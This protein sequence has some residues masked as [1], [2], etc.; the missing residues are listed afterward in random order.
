MHD[1]LYTLD[2][3]LLRKGILANLNQQNQEADNQSPIGQGGDRREDEYADGNR[4]VHGDEIRGDQ[5]GGD[6][7]TTGDINASAVAIGRGAYASFVQVIKQPALWQD[8][9]FNFLSVYRYFLLVVAVLLIALLALYWLYKDL[10]LIAWWWYATAALL[11][12]AASW[13]FYTSFP[14]RRINLRIGIS[15]ISTLSLLAILGWQSWQI[16]NPQVF[17][18][19]VF[20]IALAEVAEG[21][22]ASRTARTRE[23]TDQVYERLCLDLARQYGREQEVDPCADSFEGPDQRRVAVQRIGVI[24]DSK[25]A[26]E[27]GEQIKADV[28]IW[29]RML[30]SERGGTTLRFEVLE[31]LDKAIN[32]DF[33]VIMPVTTTSTEILGV[34]QDVSDS[35]FEVKAVAAQQAIVISSY[36]LGLIAYL[37]RDFPEAARQ[38]ETT[39]EIIQDSPALQVSS[40]GQGLIYY[41]L[42]RAYHAI[43]R[44]EQGQ[45][46]LLLAQE[47][48]PEE[49]AI[50]IS[51]ALGYGSIGPPEGLERYLQLALDKLNTWLTTNPEDSNAL[52]DRGLV[53]EIK[54]QYANAA[55]DYETLLEN[56]PGFYTAYIQMGLVTFELGRFEEAV[57]WFKQGI[58]LAE[59]EGTNPASAYVRLGEIYEKAGRP[60]QAQEAYQKAIE[61]EPESSGMLHYYAK[62]L[63]SQQEMDAALLAYQ[64]MAEVS[65]LKGW[66]YNELASFYRRR[67]LLEEAVFNYQRA[68]SADNN[69]PLYHT[70]LAKTYHE[71]GDDEN[72]LQAYEEATALNEG[73][74]IYYVYDSY[75]GFLFNTGHYAEAA[76]I[77]QKSLELRP[78]N[79]P[80]LM[81][82]GQTFNVLGEPSNTADAYCQVMEHDDTFTPEQIQAA[83]ERLENLGLEMRCP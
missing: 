35:P 21:G 1:R 19:Q 23:L 2:G 45:E 80:T 37:D 32:P 55:F 78:D 71:Q 29:G 33:P 81:N 42:A 27:F 15:V 61:L 60:V 66:A 24:P 16:A 14:P 11:L 38:I 3:T 8:T 13:A 49:P 48:N 30:A 44:V 62:F 6:K 43:N 22:N 75:G 83:K 70:Y 74:G 36:I 57:D 5:V 64:Q 28:V 68:V 54:R 63:E 52:F 51:L 10:Y 39:L 20:G 59:E 77:Y 41:Y 26:N 76:E 69:N 46:L 65:Y 72:A 17:D 12:L 73:D 34:E 56:D 53:Y 40:E 50:L 82:L 31:T 4:G 67:G 47:A 25:T 79:Y 9:I 18:P 7:I 58:A